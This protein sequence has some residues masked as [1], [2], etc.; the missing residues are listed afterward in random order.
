VSTWGTSPRAVYSEPI[1]SGPLA[2]VAE[3]EPLVRQLVCSVLARHGWRTLEV[4][5]GLDAMRLCEVEELDLLIADHEMPAVTGL[6]LVQ[7]VRRQ[8]PELPVLLLSAQPWVGEVARIH[9]YDFLPKPFDLEA[10]MSAVRSLTEKQ[11][12]VM[13]EAEDVEGSAARGGTTAGA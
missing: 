12:N 6:E 10:L 11:T 2:L 3:D 9:G 1:R 4:A 5:N 7:A 8:T 13:D